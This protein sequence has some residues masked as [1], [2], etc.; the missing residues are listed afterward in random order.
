MR[1]SGT[2]APHIEDDVKLIARMRAGD[3]DAM[4]AVY[5]RYRGIVYGVALRVLGNSTAAEDVLQEVFL[6]LWRN[7][8]GFDA[9]RGKLPAWLAVIAR[10]R[11]IDY[12]RQRPPED[13]IEDFTI[14]SNIDLEDGFAR[15]QAVERIRAIISELPREQRRSL[16]MVYFEGMTQ[17]EIA[18]KT[19]EPLGTIK[20]RIRTG[21]LT[22]RKAFE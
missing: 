3:K 21:L 1:V 16:E 15:M 19:G 8:N 17:S 6:R 18:A 12:L 10:N 20:T 4:A 2:Q 22:L 7:P 5:D 14:S 11:S 9:E 13:D